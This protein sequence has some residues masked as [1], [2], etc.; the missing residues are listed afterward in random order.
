M[1]LISEANQREHWAI[2][3]KRKKAQQRAVELTWLAGRYRVA[4]PVC[5]T[6]TRV[7]VRRLD[8][9]NLAGSCKHVQDA[10]AKCIGVD[11]GDFRKVRWIYEQ[12]KGSPK[13]YLLEVCI[14]P[15]EA[16]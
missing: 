14:Q 5:I 10:L 4:P 3:N 12:R 16:P 1:K 8:P 11:D 2:K 6:L 9:D 7:G 13:Q 15:L